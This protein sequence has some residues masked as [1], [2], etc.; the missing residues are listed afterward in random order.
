MSADRQWRVLSTYT[1]ATSVGILVLFIALGFFAV[2]D[3]TPLHLWAG[4]L[5]RVLCAV[6]FTLL[7]VLAIRLRRVAR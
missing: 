4:L 2:D 1:M 5:Q 6:W 3:G 7:I